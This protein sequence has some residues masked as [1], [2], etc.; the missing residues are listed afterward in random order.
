MTTFAIKAI[1]AL[2]QH[3][4]AAHEAARTRAGDVRAGPR[5]YPVLEG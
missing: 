2:A 4:S 5:A 3:T 1:E